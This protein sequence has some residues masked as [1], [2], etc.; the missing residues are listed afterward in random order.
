MTSFETEGSAEFDSVKRRFIEYIE[1]HTQITSS[2]LI[3]SVRDGNYR[4][5]G[6]TTQ[7][8]PANK[9]IFE[10]FDTAPEDDP[11]KYF[12]YAIGIYDDKIERFSLIFSHEEF[13]Q[14]RVGSEDQIPIDLN[15]VSPFL[16]SLTDAERAGTLV[17]E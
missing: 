15:M 5:V 10:V 2:D 1:E 17:S 14:S 13:T 16:D 12:G 4:L 7:I 11:G 9:V 8:I 3:G 6:G